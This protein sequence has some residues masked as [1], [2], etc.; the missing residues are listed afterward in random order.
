MFKLLRRRDKVK[1]GLKRSRESWFALVTQIV[2]RQRLDETLCEE[3]EEMLISADVGVATTSRLIERVRAEASVQNLRDASEVIELLK[4]EIISLLSTEAASIHR[5][6]LPASGEPL[7]I[8]TMGVNGVGK[9]TSIAKLAHYFKEQGNSVILAASDTFRAAAIE[10]LQAWGERVGVEVIAHRPGGDPAAIAYDALEAARAR[11]AN[12]VLVDTAGRL[13]TRLN[14]MEEMKKI[15]RVLSRLDPEAPHETLL[16]LDATTGQNG[17]AQARAF[18][19]GLGCTG[20]FLAKLDGT[21]RGGIVVAIVQEL[22][23]P[24]LFIGTGETME[25]MAPFEPRE[26]VEELFSGVG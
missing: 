22:G 23:L 26:F 12:V 5:C 19:E 8:L 21:A 14:L 2:Q 17:L 11:G 24:V 10:Q 16:V 25:D 4:Q 15:T 20:V 3:L 6:Q 1:A 9:T 7:V 13:H 18:A